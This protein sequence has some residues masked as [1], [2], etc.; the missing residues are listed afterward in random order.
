VA[1]WIAVIWALCQSTWTSRLRNA[2]ALALAV[3][4]GYLGLSVAVQAHVERKALEIFAARGN[5]PDQVYAMA[6]PFNILLWKVIGLREDSYDNLYLSLLD[7]DGPVE[8]YSHERHP[9]LAACL[10]ET[11]AFAKLDWFSRGYYRTELVGDDVVMSDLR[12]GLTPGYAFRFVIGERREGAIRP[13]GPERLID[14]VR[15]EKGDWAWLKTRLQGQPGVRQ[16]EAGIARPLVDVAWRR[17]SP[18]G[19]GLG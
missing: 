11:D 1:S 4:T 5:A 3:S 17:C 8:V 15:V 10:Q 9:E 18:V 7:D 6:T 14:T 13:A 2:V 19:A 12:M 16:A